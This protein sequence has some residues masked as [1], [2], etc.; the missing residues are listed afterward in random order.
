MFGSVFTATTDLLDRRFTVNVVLP[1]LVFAGGLTALAI[2]GIGWPEAL[3]WWKARDGAEQAWLAVGAVVAVVLLAYVAAGQIM[4]FTRLGEGYWPRWLSRPGVAL[5]RRRW[6]RLDLR[7]GAGYARRYHEFPIDETDLLPTRLGN[8]LRAAE[9][10][11]ADPERYGLD[12]VFFWPRLYLVLPA[13]VREQVDRCRGALDRAVLVAG[14]AMLFPLAA[15]PVVAWSGGGWRLWLLGSAA[16]AVV[17]IL[18]H[19]TAID[20]ALAFGEILRACFDLHRLTLL[21]RFGLVHPETLEAE[22]ALWMALQQQLYRR[23]ADDP[24]LLRLRPPDQP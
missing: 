1:V 13:D 9:R 12:A 22:R 17:A 16:A 10:Y 8:V 7:T 24:G 4:T 20:A 21:A 3:T 23:A 6:Q 2:A 19:R 15:V 18:A 11:P 5:Q 14:L